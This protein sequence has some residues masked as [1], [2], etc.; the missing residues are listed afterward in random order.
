VV[1]VGCVFFGIIYAGSTFPSI[2]VSGNAELAR[3]SVLANP[4][5]TQ[6]DSRVLIQAIQKIEE[7]ATR[8]FSDL[9]HRRMIQNVIA[10]V[11]LL[12]ASG[13]IILA[14]R[15]KSAEQVAAGQPAISTSIS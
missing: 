5:L 9:E 3:Q 15:K 10:L 8:G 7:S 11:F 4:R 14:F 13:F 1:N 2:A 12:E 6:D